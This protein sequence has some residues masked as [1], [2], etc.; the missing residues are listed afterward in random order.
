MGRIRP[1]YGPIS[2]F[3]LS[4]RTLLTGIH[5]KSEAT[6]HPRAHVASHPSMP[7]K[8]IESFAARPVKCLI[9]F[10]WG[11]EQ[12]LCWGCKI[13][14]GRTGQR[15]KEQGNR[16]V[17]STPRAFYSLWRPF[18]GQKRWYRAWKHLL[19]ER[20]CRIINKIAWP[21]R[22]FS[23]LEPTFTSLLLDLIR[24]KVSGSGVYLK[25]QV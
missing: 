9:V 23:I 24:A 17:L 2:S 3:L 10:N 11:R 7:Q 13:H 16:R 15:K 21:D 12:R 4:K 19:L 18:W 5:G 20:W 25:R 6:L 8:C 22:N 14:T 1:N